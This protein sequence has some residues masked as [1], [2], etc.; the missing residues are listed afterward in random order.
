M[1]LCAVFCCVL[2]NSVMIPGWQDDVQTQRLYRLW[3]IPHVGGWLVLISRVYQKMSA[4]TKVWDFQPLAKFAQ[5]TVHKYWW[6]YSTLCWNTLP[7]NV[8]PSTQQQQQ[9]LYISFPWQPRWASTRKKVANSG[10]LMAPS[11][12]LKLSRSRLS[13]CDCKQESSTCHPEI[14]RQMSFPPQSSHFTQPWDWPTV[15]W[16]ADSAAWDQ[17]NCQSLSVWVIFS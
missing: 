4:A 15:C 12:L 7:E 11:W 8:S 10:F 17:F 16:T 5:L 2:S 14:L 6:I 3:Y 1:H 9:L 13:L